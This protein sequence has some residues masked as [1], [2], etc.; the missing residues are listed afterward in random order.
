MTRG[1]PLVAIG[2]LEPH[3]SAQMEAV[4]RGCAV[5]MVTAFSDVHSD[6]TALLCKENRS[7][8]PSD[9][10]ACRNQ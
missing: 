3:G 7:L 9:T 5:A 2:S 4:S 8:P 6:K 1:T 10:P